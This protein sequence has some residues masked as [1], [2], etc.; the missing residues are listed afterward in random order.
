VS[1]FKLKNLARW[2][3]LV[4][5]PPLL[6]PLPRRGEAKLR[7][8]TSP[9]YLEGALAYRIAGTLWVP[10]R[11]KERVNP[12]AVLRG[13]QNSKLKTYHSITF[14]ENHERYY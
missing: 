8:L 10:G 6:N 1:P 14:G 2:G 5:I 12:G 3:N 13:T 7:L 4:I 9:P 11:I